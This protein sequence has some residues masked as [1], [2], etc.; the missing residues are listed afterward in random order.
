MTL[1][2]K[3]HYDLI[4]MFEKDFSHC[5]LDKEPKD[6]WSAGNIY[7]NDMPFFDELLEALKTMKKLT[8]GFR[9]TKELQPHYVAMD[10]AIAKA[11]QAG[12]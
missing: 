8:F 5:R 6:M 10:A 3:E 1:T 4:E 7:Q 2:S 12:A 11:E 9:S